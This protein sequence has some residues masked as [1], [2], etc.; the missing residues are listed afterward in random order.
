MAAGIL[1][2][3][4]LLILATLPLAVYAIVLLF[5]Y[6]NERGLVKANSS[7]I[8]LHLALGLLMTAGLFLHSVM[9][10]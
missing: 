3:S 5:R 1:P 4:V 8:L 7:T 9:L 2:L 6:Y 10:R